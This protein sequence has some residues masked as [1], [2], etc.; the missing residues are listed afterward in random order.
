MSRFAAAYAAA[1][2]RRHC[3]ADAID[4]AL[5]P[6]RSRSARCY[7]PPLFSML[8]S[9]ELLDG[10]VATPRHFADAD[11]FSSIVM[12]QPQATDDAAYYQALVAIDMFMLYALLRYYH[13]AAL[14]LAEC[15]YEHNGPEC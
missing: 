4:A 1:L 10:V 15:Y 3:A 5:S 13:A 14:T 8:A 2:R 11:C 9:P 7:A 6:E 12:L